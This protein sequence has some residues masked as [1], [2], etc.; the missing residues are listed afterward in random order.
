MVRNHV[1]LRRYRIPYLKSKPELAP[2]ND[3]QLN[4]AFVEA[5]NDFLTIVIELLGLFESEGPNWQT[6]EFLPVLQF[7]IVW[8]VTEKPEDVN[9]PK[10]PFLE[11]IKAACLACVFEQIFQQYPTK[12]GEIKETI[13]IFTLITL[14]I[15]DC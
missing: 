3:F 4:L 9:K 7:L 15:H 10:T 13:E 1:K 6:A 12:A 8:C 2:I 11:D 14:H 5:T